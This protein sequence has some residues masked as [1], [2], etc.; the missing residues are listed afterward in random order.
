MSDGSKHDIL[1]GASK[2][3]LASPNRIDREGLFGALWDRLRAD[4]IDG[5]LVESIRRFGIFEPVQLIESKGDSGLFHLV[6]GR[7]R[8]LA[9]QHLGHESIPAIVL[10]MKRDAAVIRGLMAHHPDRRYSAAQA[11]KHSRLR[12]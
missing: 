1:K 11:A 4:D 3:V 7:G 10:D 6:T 2:V 9:A 8:L 12:R 5:V